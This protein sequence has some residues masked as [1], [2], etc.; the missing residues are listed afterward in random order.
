MRTFSVPAH[1]Q[2][3]RVTTVLSAPTTKRAIP[4]P[5]APTNS[6]KAVLSTKKKGTS[7]GSDPVR[8]RR[9][10]RAAAV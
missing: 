10:E 1:S 6:P 5:M 9:P 7:G 2:L 8:K 4:D 3:L